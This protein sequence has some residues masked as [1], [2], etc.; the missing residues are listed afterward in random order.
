MTR[1]AAVAGFVLLAS[2]GTGP[3]LYNGE[4]ISCDVDDDFA[5]APGACNAMIA[6]DAGS[7]RVYCDHARRDPVTGLRGCSWSAPRTTE[8]VW[9]VCD[10]Q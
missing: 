5:L 6:R 7:G 2:C 9:V 8:C 10:E 1:L 4:A 3:A